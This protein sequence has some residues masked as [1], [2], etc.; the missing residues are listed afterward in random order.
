MQDRRAYKYVA[1][2]LFLRARAKTHSPSPLANGLRA[3]AVTSQLVLFTLCRS[4]AL[5]LFISD[6]GFS[7]GES[8]WNSARVR[9]ESRDP[10]ESNALF[11]ERETGRAKARD[12]EEH[13]EG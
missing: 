8:A 3:R 12:R 5:S 7:L 9:Q 6:P 11:V 2:L 4:L 1:I 10:S 13:R